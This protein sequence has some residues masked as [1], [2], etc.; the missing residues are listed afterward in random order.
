[1]GITAWFWISLA[2]PPLLGVITA[3]LLVRTRRL[4]DPWK[5]LAVLIAFAVLT[6]LV[7]IGWAVQLAD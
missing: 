5:V 6:L 1:M 2:I 4:Q 3:I 7:F